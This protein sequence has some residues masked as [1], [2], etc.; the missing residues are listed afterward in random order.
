MDRL[1]TAKEREHRQTPSH[2]CID[3]LMLSHTDMRRPSTVLVAATLLFVCSP[4][5][6][7]A[8]VFILESGGRLEGEWINREERPLTRYSIRQSGI[9]LTLPAGNVR[10]AIRQSPA[11]L[12]YSQLA[13]AAADTVEGQWELA[14]W[15]RKNS[16]TR[17]RE[18][19]L[20]RLIELNPDHQQARYALGYQ[21]QRGE[22]ITRAGAWR[23]EGYELYRGKWR[24]PQEIEILENN[25]RSELA[26]KEWLVRLKRWRFEL[27]HP[28]KSRLAYS[29]LT[30]IDDPIAARPIGEFFARERRRDVKALY[31]GI[32]ARIA[33]ADAIRI[34]VERALSDPDDEVFYSCVGK[35]AQ[36]QKPR[37]GVAFIAALKDNDNIKVNRAAAAL[38]RLQDKSAISPLIDALKTTHS[39]V[40]NAGP[41][42]DAT[43]TAFVNGGTLMK[44]GEGP[45]VQIV[46][47]QNQPV[48]DALTKLTGAD[49]GFDQRAWRYWYSQEKIAK[50]SSQPPLDARRN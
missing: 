1:Y 40:I 24:T 42:A 16:L 11:E 15:C 43:T 28:E 50:E 27:E 31:A 29:S 6:L 48:L 7:V 10:E 36:I 44:K 37:I 9:T 26:E 20:R 23:Q 35:L 18:V 30:S 46:H 5:W 41:G 47:V 14:E 32:L 38:A 33:T 19:H 21:F 4:A 49:F 39:R 2:H 22:W 34:L 45:E 8:D 25:S 13:P 17:Q 12:E 3:R